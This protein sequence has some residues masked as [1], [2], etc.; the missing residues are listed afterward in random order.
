VIIIINNNKGR[1]GN[2]KVKLVSP[3]FLRMLE[4]K[5]KSGGAHIKAV[6]LSNFFANQTGEV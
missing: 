4:E 2:K 5:Q 6:S 3:P 1:T